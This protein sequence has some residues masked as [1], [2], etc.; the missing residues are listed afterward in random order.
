MYFYKINFKAILSFLLFIFFIIGPS[1]AFPESTKNNYLITPL[2]NEEFQELKEIIQSK[3]SSSTKKSASEADGSQVNVIYFQSGGDSREIVSEV[4][5]KLSDSE[6][7]DIMAG[8]VELSMDDINDMMQK[9]L[10]QSFDNINGEEVDIFNLMQNMQKM[11]LIAE[12][13]AQEIP[14]Y[15]EEDVDTKALI[16]F[17]ENMNS[18]FENNFGQSLSELKEKEDIT[19][20]ELIQNFQKMKQDL[21]KD[22]TGVF[23]NL[24]IDED[25]IENIEKMQKEFNKELEKAISETEEKGDPLNM[26]K[27]LKELKK[28]HTEIAQARR[29]LKEKEEIQEKEKEKAKEKEQEEEKEKDEEKEEKAE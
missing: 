21:L 4:D 6:K 25:N 9:S 15:D 17:M 2:T 5:S 19:F 29:D 24:D 20:S 10:N 16:E 18:S 26:T 13:L 1:T 23:E 27:F 8:S 28:L 22:Q 11:G 14:E 7:T 3:K 12:K